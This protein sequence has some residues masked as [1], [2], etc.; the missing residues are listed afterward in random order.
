M[1]SQYRAYHEGELAVQTRAGVGSEGLAAE[2]MYRLAMPGGVQRFLLAQQLAVFST[3]NAGGLVWASMRSGP[4]GFLRPL[5]ESTL[6]IGGYSHRDDPLLANLVANPE[7][8]MIVIHL[9]ARHRVRL[10]GTARAYSDGRIVLST[11]QVYGNCPQYIQART[12]VGDRAVSTTPARFGQEL[13]RSQCR[14]IEQ[15][16]T[17]FI[18]TAHPQSGADAS[19]R[20]GRP[21][22]VCVEN[23]KR[24]LFPDY[25][26]NNMFNTLGN[27]VSNPRTGL[28]F[29]DFQSGS[30][31]QLSGSARILWDDPRMKRFEGAQRLVEFDIERVIELPEATLLRFEFQSY[32][33][34]LPGDARAATSEF[35]SCD[36]QSGVASPADRS[37]PG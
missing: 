8:G 24:L 11:R 22:F 1:N 28:L 4:P 21:G 16:D 13:D 30:A 14:P 34:F 10:N 27:I 12:V 29:P 33:P 17:L 32:S 36:A 31:L 6:D 37:S 5:D 3:R 35:H 19:H 20:G 18:A 15:A 9:A 2:A 7:A 23:E 25:R 26:G